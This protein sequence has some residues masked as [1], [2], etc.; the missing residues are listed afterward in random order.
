MSHDTQK[1][2]R[3]I[4][5]SLHNAEANAARMQTTNTWLMVISII[6]SAGTT[7]VTAITAARGPMMGEGPGGWK[8]SCIIA[9]ALGFATTVCVALNQQFRIA[10]RLSKANECA[11]RLKSLIVSIGTGTR[12]F[13]DIAVEYE[14]I[15]KTYPA[16]IRAR[17][18]RRR[19]FRGLLSSPLAAPRRR[20]PADSSQ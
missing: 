20:R 14:E 11:G 17:G 15:V 13:E 7:M 1:L 19:A 18:R 12:P 6:T 10:D 2:P 5:E 9:A 8:L 16:P 3:Q 4:R